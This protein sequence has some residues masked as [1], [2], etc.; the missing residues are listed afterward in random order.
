[1]PSSINWDTAH[2]VRIQKAFLDNN[3]NALDMAK[4]YD[5]SF[6]KHLNVKIK[7][8]DF[9]YNLKDTIHLNLV[10]L[11]NEGY[12]KEPGVFF[13]T[14]NYA[15]KF[16]GALNPSY[17]YRLIVT[18]ILTGRVDSAD[19]PIIDDTQFSRFY[20]D[21]LDSSAH[22]TMDFSSRTMKSFT[23]TGNYVAPVGF[24]YLFAGTEFSNP[25]SIAQ[26]IVRFRWSDS[27]ITTTVKT[28]HYYDFDAG[29]GTAVNGSFDIEIQNV[30][31]YNAL[32]TGLKSPCQPGPPARQ[33]GNIC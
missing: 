27:D 8:F 4:T 23:I 10:N 18:N 11:D 12:P 17:I 30:A 9:A 5:S 19:A 1:M 3:K 24:K 31:L 21:V 6:Y 28:P 33:G 14:P 13:T 16:T 22:L 20:I 25:V 2:Y 15:Y 32:A 29:F 26:A 7:R